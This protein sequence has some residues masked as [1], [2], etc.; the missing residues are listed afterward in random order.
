ML[1]NEDAR[2]SIYK[3]LS[4]CVTRYPIPFSLS[5]KRSFTRFKTNS[6]LWPRYLFK[7]S[8]LVGRE[9]IMDKYVMYKC[10]ELS[11]TSCNVRRIIVLLSGRVET[12]KRHDETKKRQND[13]RRQ[14]DVVS[15]E[16]NSLNDESKRASRRIELTRWRDELTKWWVDFLE[17]RVELAIWRS[18][19]RKTTTRLEVSA[20]GNDET[21]YKT[22][23]RV[24]HFFQDLPSY[25]TLLITMTVHVRAPR[26]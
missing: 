3:T 8:F 6:M 18:R 7:E 9:Q 19:S 25:R 16:S 17:R 15:D 12:M 1:N 21:P 11:S 2:A 10:M 5:W 13:K 20:C 24:E 4:R 14:T 26:Y 22:K 23:R